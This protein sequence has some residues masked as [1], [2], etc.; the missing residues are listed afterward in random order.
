MMTSGGKRR[1][2]KVER[3]GIDWRDRQVVLMVGVSPPRHATT[4]AALPSKAVLATAAAT[5]GRL[6][7]LVG[8][9]SSSPVR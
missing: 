3:G 6:H 8:T 1:P 4:V 9:V 5:P 2:V 7:G